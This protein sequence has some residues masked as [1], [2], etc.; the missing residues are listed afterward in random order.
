MRR[1]SQQV[2][3]AS[4][5]Q[6]VRILNGL[7]ERGHK[8]NWKGSD[9]V[10]V[11]NRAGLLRWLSGI[12]SEGHAN[13][14]V[15]LPLDHYKLAVDVFKKGSVDSELEEVPW[16]DAIIKRLEK[17]LSI[18]A[19]Q[20]FVQNT[21]T[22]RLK[23]QYP[24]VEAFSYQSKYPKPDSPGSINSKRTY[25]VIPKELLVSGSCRAGFAAGTGLFGSRG[26]TLF[27]H[28]DSFETKLVDL[29]EAIYKKI[30][31]LR[32]THVPTPQEVGH[33]TVSG[34]NGSDVHSDSGQASDDPGSANGAMEQVG[35]DDSD[36][37]YED[38]EDRT[39]EYTKLT[40]TTYGS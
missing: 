21:G 20:K 5:A 38:A 9:Y 36:G 10:R 6:I 27:G 14:I 31:E 33:A 28:H 37:E 40:L 18:I 39:G 17:V 26:L 19:N 16:T 8:E 23:E 4:D 2:P 32:A 24:F 12:L 1:V 22:R 25:D 15:V 29:A 30:L 13:T 35:S 34:S 7:I 11:K 3:E